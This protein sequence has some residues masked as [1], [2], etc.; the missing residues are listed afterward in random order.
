MKK[1]ILIGAG[2][3]AKACIDVIEEEKKYKILGLVEKKK[4]KNNKFMNYPILGDDSYLSKIKKKNLNALITVGQIKNSYLR[5]K[6]FNHLINLGFV[7]PIIISPKAYVSKKSKIGSGSIV[8]HNAV[9]NSSVYIGKNCIINNRSLIEHGVS[10]GNHT[11]I[12]TGAIIN[13]D[14]LIGNNSFVG[15][16]AVI[17]EGIKIGD[18]CIVGMGK[19]VK[20]NVKNKQIVK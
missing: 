20:K 5:E 15:S 6:I 7:L 19:I 2:G 9:V 13:G 14:C 3:H 8:M 4:T 1:I 16:G 12:S 11:H 17:K 10:I 18:H